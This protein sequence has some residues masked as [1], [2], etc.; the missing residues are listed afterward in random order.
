MPSDE[1]GSHVMQYDILNAVNFLAGLWLQVKVGEFGFSGL[2]DQG[3]V[4]NDEM[5][6]WSIGFKEIRLCFKIRYI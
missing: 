2:Y 5:V 1:K 3:L 6:E 4:I